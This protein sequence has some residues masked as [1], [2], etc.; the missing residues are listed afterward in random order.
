MIEKRE[1]ATDEQ[2]EER[3][4]KIVS[5]FGEYGE[6]LTTKQLAKIMNVSVATIE[7]DMKALRTDSFKWVSELAKQGYVYECRMTYAKL[8]GLSAKLLKKLKN[9]E[10]TLAVD[11]ICKLTSQIAKLEESKMQIIQSPTLYNLKVTL[12]KATISEELLG[13]S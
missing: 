10:T 4:Q 8:S 6:T 2:I 3:R 11:D 5:F 1:R 12:R 13:E 7:R 9:E